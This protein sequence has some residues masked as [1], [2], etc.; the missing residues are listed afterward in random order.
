VLASKHLAELDYYSCS[1][2]VLSYDGQEWIATLTASH[3]Y[4]HTDASV[5]VRIGKAGEASVEIHARSN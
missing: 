3:T 5:K 4:E 1:E 2:P